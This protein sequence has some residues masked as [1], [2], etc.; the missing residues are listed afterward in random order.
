MKACCSL[1]LAGDIR[2]LVSSNQQVQQ[3]CADIGGEIQF[4]V[5]TDRLRINTGDHQCSY[6]IIQEVLQPQLDEGKIKT[7]EFSGDQEDVIVSF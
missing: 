5:E 2:G 1:K 6:K 4:E 7:Y 3:M